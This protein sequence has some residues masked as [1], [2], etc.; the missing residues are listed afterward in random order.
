MRPVLRDRPILLTLL[1][2]ALFLRVAGVHLHYCQDGQ[3]PPASLHVA[4][5]G[6]HADHDMGS[7]DHRDVDVQLESAFLK[8]SK[9]G[10]DLLAIVDA[11]TLSSMALPTVRHLAARTDPAAPRGWRAFLRPPLRAPPL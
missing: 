10:G 8:S 11:P 3:E 7:E 6:L 5:A 1:V 2:A 9:L 4:D